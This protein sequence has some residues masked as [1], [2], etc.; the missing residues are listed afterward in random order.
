MGREIRSWGNPVLERRHH[1]LLLQAVPAND[2]VQAECECKGC[3]QVHKRQRKKDQHVLLPFPGK[4]WCPQQPPTVDDQ[5]K[6]QTQITLIETPSR[7]YCVSQHTLPQILAA[8]QPSHLKQRWQPALS[9]HRV[10]MAAGWLVVSV[11]LQLVVVAI[12]KN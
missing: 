3:Q 10:R 8:N 9:W 7:D 11:V 4:G 12:G 6:K 2:C 1:F 5:K